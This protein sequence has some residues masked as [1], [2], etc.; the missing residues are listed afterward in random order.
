MERRDLRYLVTGHTEGIGAE[1]CRQLGDKATGVS[2]ATGHDI[3]TEKGRQDIATLFHDHYDVLI[4][5]AYADDRSQNSLALA[6][7]E[8]SKHQEKYLVNIGS[9]VT[10]YEL[11]GE[12]L[13]LLDYQRNKTDLLKFTIDANDY[14][15]RV[16][17]VTFGY[18][19]IERILTK[20][21]LIKTITPEVA[22]KFIIDTPNHQY[23][24]NRIA[25]NEPFHQT[26]S[27]NLF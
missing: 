22:A 12:W 6:V 1:V 2:R 5:N 8:H 23:T 24:F 7:Y 16:Q 3:T 17:Y 20:Y 18:V 14:K 4:N 26:R 25:P 19:G 21:P 15:L 10:E 13:G 9:A 11:E 27:T